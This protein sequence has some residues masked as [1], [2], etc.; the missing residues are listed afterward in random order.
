MDFAYRRWTLTFPAETVTYRLGLE[1]YEID[2]IADIIPETSRFGNVIALRFVSESGVELRLAG[3]DCCKPLRLYSHCFSI[4]RD[5]D[6]AF[7]FTGSGMGH[8]CGMSQ[9]GARAMAAKHGY[10]YRQILAF[11]YTGAYVA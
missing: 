11:Y 8:N 4:S 1:G 5:K 9:W 2:P 7:V 10:T 3:R 6:G